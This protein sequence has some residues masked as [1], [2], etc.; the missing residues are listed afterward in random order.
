[1]QT[2]TSTATN[3]GNPIITTNLE[4][5]SNW[6]LTE[7]DATTLNDWSYRLSVIRHFNPNVLY[8]GYT[9]TQTGIVPISHTFTLKKG[10]IK[11]QDTHEAFY[12]YNNFTTTN[13]SQAPYGW[14][15]P[16]IPWIDYDSFL[17]QPL[18]R[19][20]F[21]DIDEECGYL[22]GSTSTRGIYLVCVDANNNITG[23]DAS[24]TIAIN[25]YDV[26][27]VIVNTSQ[28]QL[29]FNQGQSTQFFNLSGV[30]PSATNIGSIVITNITVV[31]PTLTNYVAGTSQTCTTKICNQVWMTHNLDVSKYRNGD[32][33]PQVT[34]PFQW[35]S[36][37]TGAWC[38]YNNDSTLGNVYGKLYNWYAVNDPR[39][40]APTGWHVPTS[41]ETVTL[42]QCLGQDT[43]AG[44]K[45]K[46]TGVIHWNSP[47]TN[48]SNL[49]NFTALPAGT[50]NGGDG[51][52]S[53]LNLNN[54]I[55]TTTISPAL[56][57][58]GMLRLLTYNS[59]SLFQ[60]NNLKTAGFSVRCLKD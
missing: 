51:S 25:I 47:N 33:I 24:L 22:D 12:L 18:G 34:D 26:N 30:I 43:V 56:P 35:V 6:Y 44:G 58:Q 1:M 29:G 28:L 53:D 40:L 15:R 14:Y 48:A 54:V 50:R 37:T 5:S 55:W 41:L 11:T 27:G 10:F 8:A 39:G 60:G 19:T 4:F 17:Y 46:E 36:L 3:L 49:Y 38:Y 32:V 9:L 23:L 2:S 7:S 45:L 31:G 20:L 59:E 21:I 52:F 16:L 13:Y 57:N 42:S